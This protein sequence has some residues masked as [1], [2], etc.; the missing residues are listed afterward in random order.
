MKVGGQAVIEGVMMKAKDFWSVA[1]RDTKG[2]IHVKKEKLKPLPKVLKLPLLRGVVS[3][4]EALVLGIKA[5]D[6][7]A[8]KVYAEEGEKPLSGTAIG[9]TM[10]FSFVLGIGLFILLPLYLTKLAGV[11]FSSVA[12]SSFMFNLVDGVIRV[13]FFLIYI[14]I[15]SLWKD[16]RRVF[17][18]HGAE[19][20]VIFAYESGLGLG[21][22]NVRRY[23]THHPRCGTSFIFIVMI[24]SIFVFSLIPKPWDFFMKFG[25]RIVLIPLIAGISYE[26][27]KL[28]AKMSDNPIVKLLIQPGLMLQYITTKEP[29]DSQ[30]EVALRALMEVVPQVEAVP[31]MEAARQVKAVSQ[32]VP[33]ME[34]AP[35]GESS[36]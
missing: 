26:V 22:D 18:Y 24:L 19:H 15:V 16:M 25:S 29:D 4:Y 33:Q 23:G 27:L 11:V 21:M 28:S 17:E 13:A 7:S 6:Y 31:Q 36:E 2:V 12:Q 10:A 5:L 1:V 35:Q 8:S 20:K 14:S 3:L 9:M 32:M 30:V 34:V